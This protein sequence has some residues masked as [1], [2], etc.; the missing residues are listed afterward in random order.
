MPDW[1]EHWL[2][3]NV[4]WDA[5]ASAPIL[6]ELVERG[7]LP[8]GRALVPGCGAGYDAFTLAS[9]ER[10]VV[11][12]D[13][14]PSS[15]ARFEELRLERAPAGARIEHRVGDFFELDLGAPFDLIWDYTFLCALPIELR[16]AWAARM[17][18]LLRPGGELITLIFPIMEVAEG[19]AGPPWPMSPE[20]VGGLLEGRFES[21][22][23]G[24]VSSSH[25]GREG[26]E[27]L[28]RWRRLG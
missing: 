27:W 9:T 1:E 23:L 21:T 18:S 14:A 4:P 25:P 5:G 7:G 26:K 6:V 2:E 15:R 11:G 24:P 16:E 8:E 3:R 28:G 19:Y 22:Q 12:L 20:L 10:E 13:L 17:A